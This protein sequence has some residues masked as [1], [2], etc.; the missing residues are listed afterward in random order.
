MKISII[1][2]VKNAEMTIERCIRSILGQNCKDIELII[3]DGES[4]DSTLK[5]INKYQPQITILISERDNGIYDAMNKGMRHA[6]GDIWAFLNADDWY[7]DGVLARVAEIFENDN[8]IQA[9][10]GD[11]LFENKSVTSKSIAYDNL[12]STLLTFNICH[13]CVFARKDVFECIGIFDTE[14]RLA[15]EYDWML[16][17]ALSGMRTFHDNCFYVHYTTGGMSEQHTTAHAIDAWNSSKKW[18]QDKNLLEI[19]KETYRRNI[20][21]AYLNNVLVSSDIEELTNIKVNLTRRNFCTDIVIYGAGGYGCDLKNILNSVAINVNA[22]IDR[23][24]QEIKVLEGIP[25]V[26][27]ETYMKDYQNCKII[28]SPVRYSEIEKI[29]A[30]N[31]L[32]KNN[33]YLIL[34]EFL[35]DLCSC[36]Q[37]AKIL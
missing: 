8:G 26:S 16:R 33:D 21:K 30:K 23:N 2:V 15:A 22:F 35:I 19:A 1:T 36:Q 7:C 9:I 24:H 14:Y 31:G 20:A 12:L 5:I 3:I 37:N 34:M 17:L 13:Q 29:L 10:Y 28:V 18:I 32:K 25:V 27:L 6:R 11:V 4:T